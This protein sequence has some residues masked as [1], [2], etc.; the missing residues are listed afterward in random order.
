M[1]ND[2]NDFEVW[3]VLS[4]AKFGKAYK[5]PQENL[6]HD[7]VKK[8]TNEMLKSLEE[9]LALPNGSVTTKILETK[10][11]LWGAGVPL[12]T[13]VQKKDSSPKNDE[14]EEE[15]GFLYDSK[16][17]VGACGDW[18]LD[19]SIAGA[20]ESGRRLADYMSK[21]SSL[22]LISIGLEGGTFKASSA[23]DK[24]GIGSLQ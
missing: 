11:Q 5:G 19:P 8:V 10:L 17:G 6:P 18:L 13:W 16:Y 9:S 22:S 7:L 23:V 12:N 21:S 24:A 3:T 1:E 20:W 4:S 2:T 15:Q 14:D